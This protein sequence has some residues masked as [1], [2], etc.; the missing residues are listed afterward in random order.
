MTIRSL[1]HIALAVPDPAAGKKFYTDF[2]MEGREEGRRVVMR[3]HGRD[4]DQVI[5]VEGPERRT[6]HIGFGASAQGLAGLRERLEKNG[7]K[8]TDAPK[9]TP[10][11]GLWFRDMD[12][13][14]INVRVAEP[15]P[16][17]HAPD[18]KINNPGNLNRSGV[19]GYPP[20]DAAVQPRRLGHTLRFTAN[21]EKQLDFY[22]RVVGMKLSDRARDIVAFLRSGEGGSD[23]HVL[24]FIKSDRP[25]YHHASFEV[26][27]VDE[28]GLGA[29]RLIDKG[30][31]N[32]WGLGRHVIG[33]NFFHYIRD[34]WGSLVEYFC[35]IDYIPEGADWKPR[36]YPPEDSL[37]V[38]GPSVPEDFGMNFEPRPD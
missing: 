9:E 7:I 28:V 21:L 2:G 32:G 27:N 11:D 35:D 26:G 5:L 19:P 17:L 14:L 1:Q 23:H 13:V 24:G 4:Q 15:A 30:Y 34:P 20:R 18:W 38:W 31:R 12:G 29:C 10:G 16:W 37:Y 6:H 8:L 33:S 3:C 25:G 22:T 36:D